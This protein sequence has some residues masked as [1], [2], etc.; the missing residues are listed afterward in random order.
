MSIIDIYKYP[1]GVYN[2]SGGVM[3]YKNRDNESKDKLIKRLNIIEGQIKGIKQMISD[4]RYC[5]DILIQISSVSKSLNSLGNVI[6]K[7]HLSSCVLDDIKNGDF[8]SFD[9]VIDMISKFNK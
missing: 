6:L 5:S 8:D 7:E 1:V 3:K 4:N 2:D 9:E